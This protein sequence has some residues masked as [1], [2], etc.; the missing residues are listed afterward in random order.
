MA[1]ATIRDYRALDAE[2]LNRIS[3]A[4]FSQFK[5]SYEDWSAMH[6]IVSKAS[7]LSET[8]EVRML[9]AKEWHERRQ[10]LVKLGGPPLP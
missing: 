1:D 5:D 3:V 2:D 8:G 6:T 7:A 9:D 10:S 4:A